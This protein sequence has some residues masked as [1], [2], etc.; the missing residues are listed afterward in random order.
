[1]L[2]RVEMMLYLSTE[3]TELISTLTLS[4]KPLAAVV[5]VFFLCS[6]VVIIPHND[7]VETACSLLTFTCSE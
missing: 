7:L 2:S 5:E 3:Y 1:M 4:F 6:G